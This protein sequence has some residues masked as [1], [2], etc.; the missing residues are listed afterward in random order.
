MRYFILGLLLA[1]GACSNAQLRDSAKIYRVRPAY[2][3]PVA[4][5]LLVASSFGFKA[6]DKVAAFTEADLARLDPAKVNGFDRPVIFKDPAMVARAQSRADF[7][8]NFSIASPVVLMLDRKIR[9]DW[10]DML[11][12]YLAAHV[13]DNAVYFAAAFPI[14]RAR[15]FTYN[16]EV[17]V[18]LRIGDAKSNSFFS[19]HTSFS[20]TSTFFLAKVLTD[21][22]HIRGWKRAGIYAIA[23]VP[24]ALVGYYRVQAAR[25][26]RTDVLLGFAVGAASGI[27]VPEL[28]KQLNRTKRVSLS[29]YITPAGQSGFCLNYRF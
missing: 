18:A 5:G 12:L 20:A 8:L 27:L 23:S 3:L 15:P 4:G 29:P 6:L 22:N 21:Y 17:P 11:S 28:H 10:L 1:A 24:P 9:K 14:R 19:G 25:H 13:V 16:A 7:F 2:E 26:F